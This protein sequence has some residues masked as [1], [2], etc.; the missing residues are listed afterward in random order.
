MLDAAY[1]ERRSALP[2]GVVWTRTAEPSA[3]SNRVLPDGCMDLIW[4]DGRLLVAGPDTSAQVLRNDAGAS[5]TG[6]RFAPGFAPSVLGV[7]GHV[8]RDDR[9]DLDALWPGAEVRRI[10]D[11]VASSPDRGAALER[12]ARERLDGAVPTSAW[13]VSAVRHLRSGATVA[14]V[15][16]SLGYS[17]RQ[18]HRRSLDAFGYGLKTLARVLRMTRALDLARSGGELASVAVTAGY[19]DQ[20]HFAR[21][22]KLLAGLPITELLA[23]RAG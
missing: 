19:A 8:L 4:T 5:V 15:A 11:L 20:P 9:V 23:G 6:L 22:V 10:T 18:L 3:T 2:G 17:E 21:D 13:T 12:V 16:G 7:P 1:S 14:S